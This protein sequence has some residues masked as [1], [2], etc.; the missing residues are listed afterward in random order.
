[1]NTTRIKIIYI[2]L[3]VCGCLMMTGAT[4]GY[5]SLRKA[6][7]TYQQTTG[8]I[9]H[10]EKKKVRRHRKNRYEYTKRI[11]YHTPQYGQLHTY[12]K[13]FIPFKFLNDS[14]TVYYNPLY[15]QEVKI[16]SAESFIWTFLFLIGGGCFFIGIL[17]MKQH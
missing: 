5:L 9:E 2:I 8:V 16:P 15:P 6:M 1:M 13:R 3:L 14:I 17:I 7:N 11:S 10:I 12:T 4:F